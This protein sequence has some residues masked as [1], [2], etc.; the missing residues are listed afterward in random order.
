[1]TLIRNALVYTMED[2]DVPSR[3]DVLFGDGRIAAVG[4]NLTGDGEVVDAGGLY[5]LPGLIDAHTHV[6]TWSVIASGP[7]DA[8]EPQGTLSPHLNVLHS[9]DLSHREFAVHRRTG[10]TAVCVTP[11]SA[12]VIDGMAIVTKTAGTSV[13]DA[14]I[15]NPC[16][17]KCAM[18]HNP[19][20]FGGKNAGEPLTRMGVY[21]LLDS[22]LSKARRYMDRLAQAAGDEEKKPPFDEQSEAILPVLRREIPLK[23]H[24]SGFDMVTLIGLAKKHD[25]LYTI[26]HGWGADRFYR[27]L[28]EGGGPVMLGPLGNASLPDEEATNGEIRLAKELDDR[29]VNVSLITDGPIL[30]PDI[31]LF[32]A[33]EAVR[34]G[35]DPVRALRTITINPARALGVDDR[36]GSIKEGKD[37]DLVLFRGE[38]A[39]DMAACPVRVWIDG[40]TVYMKEDLK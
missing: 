7:M 32:G 18:G 29:G 25:L 17:L 14:V 11:G 33:G 23:V 31:L 30:S 8:N 35:M 20:G 13:Y 16:A 34:E 26:E 15:K 37:A 24:C 10:V 6:G 12:K 21:A 28:A 27:E 5:L 22:A 4:E 38:P 2:A 1:M 3:R 39:V 9:T 36:I 19:K 40:K